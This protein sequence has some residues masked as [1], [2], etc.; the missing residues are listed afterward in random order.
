MDG[1][2]SEPGSVVE[3]RLWQVY[4]VA[5]PAARNV[6]IALALLDLLLVASHAAQLPVRT[7]TTADGLPRDTLNCVTPDSR[8]FLW[9]CTSEGLARF[10]GYQFRTYGVDQG[11]LSP[12]IN[13]F[14]ETR[15][16]RL[17]A[18]TDSGL[19]VMK[20]QADE[21]THS[22]FDI[23]KPGPQPQDLAI[24]ALLEDSQGVLW[25]GTQGGLFR[26][27]WTGSSPQ[28][29]RVT[30]IPVRDLA[31][32]RAGNLWGAS[33]NSGLLEISRSG[34]IRFYAEMQGLPATISA[35]AV[36]GE[37]TVWVG[38]TAGLCKLR[39]A[40]GVDGRIVERVYITEI[41][42]NYVIACLYVTRSGRLWAGSWS[43]A[44]EWTGDPKK[45]VPAQPRPS[46][47]CRQYPKKRP[48][49]EAGEGWS[50]C[51]RAD[52]T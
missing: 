29:E 10:D 46:G 32:D 3:R 34:K 30:T 52:L 14:I 35:V 37:G 6:G 5:V 17:L 26:I 39:P 16:G 18:G 13:T 24:Y 40:P 50:G 27:R 22:S 28:F 1:R 47:R 9:L 2:G 31:E 48:V 11:L 4:A 8:G 19:A 41:S 49:G 7:Y 36:D 21:R 33:W 43:G 51:I 23:Y 44:S 12:F 25:C 45:R 42:S 20:L 38:T 15:S